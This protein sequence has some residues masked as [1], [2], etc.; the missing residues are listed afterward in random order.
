MAA[1][2]PCLWD[3]SRGEPGQFRDALSLPTTNN[4]GGRDEARPSEDC[5]VPVPEAVVDSGRRGDYTAG[6]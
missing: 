4:D 1:V 3:K 6:H 5:S 2:Y